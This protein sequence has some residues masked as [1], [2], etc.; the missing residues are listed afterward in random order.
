[1]NKRRLFGLLRLLVSAILIGYFLRSLS[2]QQGGLNQA[3][4]KVF[5][6]FSSASFGWLVPAILLH[7]IGFALISLR[8]KFMLRAQNIRAEFSQLFLYYFMA[9][10]FNTFLPSTI[11]GDALRAMESKK[12]TGNAATSITVV[13]M[14]RITGLVALIAIALTALLIQTLKGETGNSQIWLL[15]GLL[16]V[17]GAIG[18]LLSR[19]S[20]AN[21]ILGFFCRI[22][23]QKIGYFLNQSYQALSVYF[24]RPVELSLA[25]LVSLIFQLNMVFYYYLIARSLGQNPDIIDF[26]IKVPIMIV[27][28]MTVPAIN[29]LGIRTASFRGLMK[30]PPAYAISGELIDLGMRVGY[31]L[32]GG[33]VFL[34]YRRP[35]PK[36][37]G[38]RID[39]VSK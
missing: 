1:M 12:L 31:G 15:F 10:F 20:I 18:I 24:H 37:D 21:R 30:F 32:L 34:I 8:W 9:A 35:E 27:L 33:L 28:L 26:M 3:L 39:R 11:G 16:I 22:L 17:L 23:P 14:E 29:G 4:S 25:L 6:A 7:P 5:E 13:I 36:S 38:S 2:S 19:P